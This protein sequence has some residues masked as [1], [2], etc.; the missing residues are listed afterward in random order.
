MA[1]NQIVFERPSSNQNGRERHGDGVL[2]ACSTG[3]LFE[4]LAKACSLSNEQG[5]MPLPPRASALAHICETASGSRV[6]PNGAGWLAEQRK[7]RR[8]GGAAVWPGGERDIQAR[9]CG[10]GKGAGAKGH[11]NGGRNEVNE[12][13]AL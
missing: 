9:C 4:Q 12:K 5:G 13:R 8:G 2:L 1:G 3:R 7:G 11:C 10:G 6:P